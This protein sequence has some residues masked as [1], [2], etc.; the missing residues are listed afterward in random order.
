MGS[1]A[2]PTPVTDVGIV[3]NGTDRT[4]TFMADVVPITGLT[5]TLVS[6]GGRQ[7]SVVY[8]LKSN[9]AIDGQVDRVTGYTQ[10]H[11][12]FDNGGGN[13]AFELKCRPATRMF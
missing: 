1:T 9:F 7:S 5:A 8:G 2:A 4:V 10:V 13:T 11:Y 3:V 6:F 12:V